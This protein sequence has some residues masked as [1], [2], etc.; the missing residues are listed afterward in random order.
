[1]GERLQLGEYSSSQIIIFHQPRFPWNK[2]FGVIHLSD[3]TLGALAPTRTSWAGPQHFHDSFRWSQAT[4]FKKQG[5]KKINPSFDEPTKIYDY[6]YNYIYTCVYKMFII[7]IYI[8]YINSLGNQVTRCIERSIEHCHRGWGV[9]L[10]KCVLD[11][12]RWKMEETF[13]TRL[14]L[15]FTV[16]YCWHHS[17]L[18]SGRVGFPRGWR[19]YPDT[20]E[21]LILKLQLLLFPWY[22]LIS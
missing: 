10:K 16:P 8:I 20:T 22:I 7:Y 9:E 3:I 13:E 5:T 6:I 14:D 18:A 2:Q 11:T 4:P 15:W 1:M 19:E 17:W 21:V 12:R